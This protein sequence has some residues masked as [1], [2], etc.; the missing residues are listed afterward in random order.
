MLLRQDSQEIQNKSLLDNFP[1]LL[2]PTDDHFI[3]GIH[4]LLHTDIGTAQRPNCIPMRQVHFNGSRR[5]TRSGK[6]SNGLSVYTSYLSLSRIDTRQVNSTRYL[7]GGLTKDRSAAPSN[8]RY[9]SSLCG[10]YPDAHC[11]RLPKR[12]R[13]A[14][15]S[16]S[17]FRNT[18]A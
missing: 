12:I 16:L 9:N 8:L 18:P 4:L 17:S 10:V 14:T 3:D 7:G 5:I 11:G 13:T 2:T 1:S 15:L 6:I